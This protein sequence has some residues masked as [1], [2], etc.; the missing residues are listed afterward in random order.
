MSLVKTLAEDSVH[1]VWATLTGSCGASQHSWRERFARQTQ[2]I[3]CDPLPNSAFGG[4][5]PAGFATPRAR[6]LFSQ[7]ASAPMDMRAV[8]GRGV[9]S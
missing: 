5:L 1:K 6:S 9:D 7:S 4:A 2:D 8:L 3:A